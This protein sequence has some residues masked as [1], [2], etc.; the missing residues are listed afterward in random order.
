MSELNKNLAELLGIEPKYK[1]DTYPTMLFNTV[2]EALNFDLSFRNQRSNY[3]FCPAEFKEV[4]LDFTSPEN[5]VKLLKLIINTDENDYLNGIKFD[6]RYISCG[7]I[8]ACHTG[9][10]IEETFVNA[11]LD[12]IESELGN[13]EDDR[14]AYRFTDQLKQQS[15]KIEWKY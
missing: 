4:Y 15:Q 14:D 1:S 11:V 7:N 10:S 6:K 13:F 9:S 2:E 12:Y 3:D 8:D 5:F